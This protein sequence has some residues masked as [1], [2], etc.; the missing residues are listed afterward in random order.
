MVKLLPAGAYMMPT[1]CEYC[2][3]SD[4]KLCCAETCQRPSYYLQKKRPPFSKRDSHV[5]HPIS[6]HAIPPPP[7]PPPPPEPEEITST[8]V[9]QEAGYRTYS[10]APRLNLII[11]IASKVTPL[12]IIIN[13]NYPMRH[14]LHKIEDVNV[15]E[16]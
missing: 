9:L 14:Y 15:A 8:L 11:S 7:L 3:E 4:T 13:S 1:E 5:W 6:D 10:D 12:R 2:G 16:E